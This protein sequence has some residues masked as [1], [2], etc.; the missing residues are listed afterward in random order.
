MGRTCFVRGCFVLPDSAEELANVFIVV[1]EE[2]IAVELDDIVIAV[3]DL[4]DTA[5][6]KVPQ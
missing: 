2:I 3:V 1:T 5:I 4:A 6:A